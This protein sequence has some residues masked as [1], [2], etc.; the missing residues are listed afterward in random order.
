M[1]IFNCHIPL[2]NNTMEN[3]DKQS[4]YIRA[5]ER[6]EELKKFYGNLF[7]YVVVI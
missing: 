3:F 4:K 6:V 7:S 5:K 1:S 2:K